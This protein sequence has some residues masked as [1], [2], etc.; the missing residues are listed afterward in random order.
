MILE[1]SNHNDLVIMGLR[2]RAGSS[3]LHDLFKGEL[4]Y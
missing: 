2:E 3:C 4:I 1:I